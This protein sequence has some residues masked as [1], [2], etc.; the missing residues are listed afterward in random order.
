VRFNPEVTVHFKATDEDRRFKSQYF[1][2][3]VLE[4]DLAKDP[5]DAR[6]LMY[7]GNTFA[8]VGNLTASYNA[9]RRL[10]AL[11][12]TTTKESQGRFI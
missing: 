1:I 12:T 9:W 3:K 8:T 2:I 4:E 5:H 7:L 6:A 10:A 11:T